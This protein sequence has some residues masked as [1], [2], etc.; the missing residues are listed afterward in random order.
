MCRK[1]AGNENFSFSRWGDGEFAVALGDVGENCDGAK[2]YSD[3]GEALRLVLRSKPEYY[4]GM[5]P[6][7]MR[8]M[9]DRITKWLADEG[10]DFDWCNADII[11]DASIAGDLDL[12]SQSLKGRRVICVMPQKLAKFA[13]YMRAPQIV[14]PPRIGW[15]Y[16][17]TN[18]ADLCDEIE[19]IGDDA[20]VLYCA[21]M[22]S[23][24]FIHHVWNDYGDKVT[25]I[26][27][28]SVLEPY[29]TGKPTRRYHVGI[30]E[31]MKEEQA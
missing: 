27:L 7:G 14:V 15:K 22:S 5:Q 13:Q 12:L 26:D 25:Q 28:G 2:Y 11:H 30:L 23:E 17:R 20:V 19:Y 24:V 10:L 6:K 21:G 31:R 18:Y 29:V 3:L 4:L 1:L 16:Y 9:G 8:D